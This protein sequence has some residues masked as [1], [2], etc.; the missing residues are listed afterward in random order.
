M[1]EVVEDIAESDLCVSHCDGNQCGDDG[2][3]GSCGQCSCGES[4]DDGKCVFHACDGKVCGDDGCGGECGQ[5][6]EGLACSSQGVCIDGGCEGDPLVVTGEFLNSV[7]P[8]EFTQVT[9]TV[10]HKRDVDTWEDGCISELVLDFT[11]GTGCELTIRAADH[12]TLDGMLAIQELTFT[13]SS[14]CPGFPDISEGAYIGTTGMTV[15]G[16]DLGVSEVPD[17]NAAD[18]CFSTTMAVHLSGVLEPVGPG[19][20]LQVEPS[21]LTIEGSF[22]STGEFEATCPCQPV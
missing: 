6:T 22:F 3:G 15:A 13:A 7:S 11:H 21:I 19:S 12:M 4:C 18:S 2:C 8:V 20:D 5:C 9:A 17:F 16:I 10:T 14:E 1:V